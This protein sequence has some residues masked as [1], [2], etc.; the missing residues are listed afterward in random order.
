MEG[1]LAMQPQ[2]VDWIKVKLGSEGWQKLA[3]APLA[4][5]LV[6]FRAVKNRT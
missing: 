2:E 1:G 4:N 5:T 3:G 6:R